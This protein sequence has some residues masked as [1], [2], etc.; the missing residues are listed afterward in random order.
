MRAHM[1]MLA[2]RKVEAQG[3]PV[4]SK[5]PRR[6]WRPL[7]TRLHPPKA[8]H[9]QQPQ[10]EQ[11]RIQQAAAPIA[12]VR[13]APAPAPCVWRGASARAAWATHAIKEHEC[14]NSRPGLFNQ[15]GICR[16][17]GRVV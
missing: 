10:P 4:L 12:V 1:D 3:Q 5:T 13:L 7:H 2:A 11:Q 16:T 9:C 15:G 8:V 17:S 6:P 14:A